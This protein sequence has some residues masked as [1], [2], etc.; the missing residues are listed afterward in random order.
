MA[1]LISD[2][3]LFIKK[4][5]LH[6]QKKKSHNLSARENKALMLGKWWFLYQVF[7]KRSKISKAS[8]FQIP[9]R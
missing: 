3:L 1:I 2:I 8:G 7:K 9:I 4:F 5:F 6:G